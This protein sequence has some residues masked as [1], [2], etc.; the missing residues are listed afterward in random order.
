MPEHSTNMGWPAAG[1]GW[2]GFFYSRQSYLSRPLLSLSSEAAFHPN[3]GGGTK[4]ILVLLN[5][6]LLKRCFNMFKALASF[7]IPPLNNQRS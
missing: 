3:L 4:S 6:A 1:A 2:V 7:I 5:E